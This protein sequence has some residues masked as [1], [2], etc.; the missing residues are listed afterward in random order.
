MK[1]FVTPKYDVAFVERNGSAALARGIIKTFYP[2]LE[3]KIQNGKYPAGKGPDNTLWQ[4]IIS[5]TS[6]PIHPVL[7][8]VRNPLDRFVSACV[9]SK[10][11]PDD[12]LT[13][14][15]SGNKTPGTFRKQSDYLTVAKDIELY[16]FPDGLNVIAAKL[17]FSELLVVNVTDASAK[18]KLTP[19]QE[20]RVL[21][22][23]ADDAAL[24]ASVQFAGQVVRA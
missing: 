11:S 13:S 1:F 18:P 9:F 3:T 15:E 14:L 8:V 20:K 4:G 21:A 22:Y 2:E 10:I 19:E 17:G 24:Y 7:M 5:V 6:E 23:Y 16:R 12:A